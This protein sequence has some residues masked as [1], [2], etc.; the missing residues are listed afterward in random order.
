V[1]VLIAPDKFKH[2][3]TAAE[4]AAALARGLAAARPDAKIE[5]VPL[6]DGGDGTGPVLAAALGARP[7]TATVT[8][9]RGR[10]IEATWW[11]DAATRTA[12]IEMAEASGLRL[13][14]PDERDPTQTTSYGTGELIA[15]AQQAGASE[16]LLGVGGSATVDG[17]SG[18][19]QALGWTLFDSEGA[20][21]PAPITGGQLARVTTLAPPTRTDRPR[22]NVLCDVDNP[23]IGR[24]GAA[25]AF[26]PQ[27]GA[28]SEQVTQ[29]TRNLNN[30]ADVLRDAGGGDV[31]RLPATGAAGGLPAGLLAACSASLR[32]GFDA[33]AEA[34][35]LDARIAA[36]DWCVTGEG[37]IDE[38]TARGK[39]VAGV[40]RRAV[41]LKRPV[42][43]FVGDCRGSRAAIAQQLSLRDIVVVTPAGM[44]LDDALGRTAENLE[45]AAR[46]YFEEHRS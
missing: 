19:L 40:A 23:L 39:V 2:A 11:W 44:P 31:R 6:A 36:A 15:V 20:A 18:V 25:P 29:L 9:P 21:L 22:I 10:P 26:G 27:K 7:Q 33:V 37:R 38:Q 16:V 46:H 34:V 32:L 42:A 45:T 13:L 5:C 35:K 1:R 12:I 30:W 3:L 4:V 17:G 28:S 43:A 8:G 14:R 41:E 24:R